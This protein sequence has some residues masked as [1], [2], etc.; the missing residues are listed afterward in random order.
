MVRVGLIGAGEYARAMLLPHFKASGVTFRAISTAS[1]VTARDVGI[2][3]GFEY[4][5]AGPDEVIG[6]PEIDL[7]IVATRHNLHAELAR[8]ALDAGRDVFV[9][10]PLALQSQDLDDVISAAGLAGGRLVVGFNRRFSPLAQKAKEFFSGRQSPLSITYRVSA[11]RLPQS[12]WIRD[13]RQGGGRIVGEVCHFVDLIH[14][15]T[16]SLTTR[17]YAESVR[18]RSQEPQDQDSVIITLRLAD[19]SNGSIAYIASGDSSVPKEY[20]EIY[21]AE[22]TFVIDDFRRSIS[23]SQGRKKELKLRAKDKGQSEQARAVCAMVIEGRPSP[24]TLADLAA[25]TRATFAIEESLRTG[26]PCEI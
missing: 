5:A 20:V 7:V 13:P 3:Y 14:F 17:V 12:H 22:K 19:G 4:S 11:A 24:F 10:K 26:Q 18:S 6:D 2:Q 15:L 21:G 9:E 8:R 16:G 23:F 25:T 1:G